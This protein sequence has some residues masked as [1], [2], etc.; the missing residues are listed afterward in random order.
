MR[1]L[2]HITCLDACLRNGPASDTTAEL[3][4]VATVPTP[5]ITS[6]AYQHRPNKS[7]NI[8]STDAHSVACMLNVHIVPFRRRMARPSVFEPEINDEGK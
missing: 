5:V 8:P 3:S 2:Y 6:P 4:E 7:Q 1:K